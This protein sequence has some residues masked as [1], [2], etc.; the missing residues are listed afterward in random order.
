LSVFSASELIDQLRQKSHFYRHNHV[1]FTVGDDFRFTD[2]VE[3][4]KQFK[5]LTQIMDYI[6]QNPRWNVQV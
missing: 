4:E 6:N 1:M 3:W 2:H 5:N